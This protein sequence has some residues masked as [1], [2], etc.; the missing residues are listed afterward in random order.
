MLPSPTTT[1]SKFAAFHNLSLAV[2]Y[3][4]DDNFSSG[5]EVRRE[6]F[7]QKFDFRDDQNLLTIIEQQPNFTTYYITSKYSQNLTDV[8]SPYIQLSAGAN[9]VGFVGKFT[10]GVNY[11]L[12]NDFGILLG[13]EYANMFY[14]YRG[15][16]FNSSKIGF[17]W[18]LNY[19][20]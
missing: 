5:I 14:G 3:E 2:N 1:P 20:F 18:G 7:F 15:N 10:T 8:I 4:F 9:K 6:T 12:T 16:T 13:V 11:D 19:K 17:L